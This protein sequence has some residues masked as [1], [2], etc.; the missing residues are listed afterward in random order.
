MKHVS[1]TVPVHHAFTP[2]PAEY[3]IL[4]RHI[5]FHPAQN[6]DVSV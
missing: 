4:R 1:T 5:T 6:V 3:H 2:R